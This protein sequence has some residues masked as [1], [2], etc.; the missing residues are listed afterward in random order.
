[1][2]RA[3]RT[4]L[5]TFAVALPATLPAA[6]GQ[7]ILTADGHTDTYARIEA[8]LGAPPETPDCSDPRFGP[9]I[10]QALDS[11][12][13]AYV[14]VFNIHVIP[15]DDRCMRHDRQRVEI[16]TDLNSPD[17][18]KGFLNDSVTFRWR[19]KLPVGFRPSRDFTHIHQIKAADGDSDAPIMTLTPR[20]NGRST[21]EVNNT[22]SSGVTRTLA[23]TS[24]DPFIGEWVEAY[25][26]LTYGS[27]G[28]YSIVLRR[29]RDNRQLLAY[30]GKNIDLWRKGTTV[31][32]PKW[33]IYRSLKDR[34]Q[35]RNE[36]VE[37]ERFCL[38]KG[39]DDCV[40]EPN[41]ATTNPV[42]PAQN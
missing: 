22:N 9:H 26:K 37:F 12:L 29:V 19:F 34:D 42:P 30:S 2:S 21:L 23:E 11:Q 15:D 6:F 28:T 17:Y 40:A 18:V 13:G 41:A 14:F 36:Q 25:E 4:A 5:L 39:T 27:H 38:A 16:K 1:M 10:T 35:L 8:S 20:R 32:R 33:G 3:F 24:L 7:V 31:A